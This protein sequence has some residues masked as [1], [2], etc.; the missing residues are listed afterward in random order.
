MKEDDVNGTKTPFQ[1]TTILAAIAGLIALAAN[2]A[3]GAH[4]G[5]SDQTSIFNGLTD[6][7]AAVAFVGSIFGRF[8]ATRAVGYAASDPITA[9]DI[10]KEVAQAIADYM[11]AQKTEAAPAAT[12]QAS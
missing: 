11:A 7:V 5:A 3:F 9:A 12:P 4:L 6:I 1:S 2:A 10:G 8:N